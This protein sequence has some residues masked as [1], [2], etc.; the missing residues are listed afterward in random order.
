MALGTLGL[1]GKL[2]IPRAAH[3]KTE[4]RTQLN[5]S[6]KATNQLGQQRTNQAQGHVHQATN[7]RKWTE[8]GRNYLDFSNKKH[9]YFVAKGFRCMQ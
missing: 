8:T 7:R 1:V 2:T 9:S 5:N 6:N 3:T 4:V